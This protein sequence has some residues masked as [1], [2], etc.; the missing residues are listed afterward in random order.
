MLDTELLLR[1]LSHLYEYLLGA[2]HASDNPNSSEVFHQAC[3]RLQ[4]IMNNCILGGGYIDVV[5][6][7]E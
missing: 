2:H 6:I 7:P 4:D 1:D 3:H 5:K